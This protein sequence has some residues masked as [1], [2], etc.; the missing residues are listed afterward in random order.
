MSGELRLAWPPG[1]ERK[2]GSVRL[3]PDGVVVAERDA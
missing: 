1:P 2:A 3:V